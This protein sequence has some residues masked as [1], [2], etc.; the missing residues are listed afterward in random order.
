MNI[1][2]QSMQEI[3]AVVEYILPRRNTLWQSSSP[4]VVLRLS[5]LIIQRAHMHMIS[6]VLMN[7]YREQHTVKHIL[8]SLGWSNTYSY[9]WHTVV[10]DHQSNTAVCA[11]TT[12]SMQPHLSLCSHTSWCLFCSSSSRVKITFWRYIL[13]RICNTTKCHYKHRKEHPKVW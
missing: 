7:V 5:V 4:C 10:L 11:A 1:C 9:D 2:V 8:N 13:S 6:L 12:Q 3:H